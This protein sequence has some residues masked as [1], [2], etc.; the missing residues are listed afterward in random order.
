[1]QAL[2]ESKGKPDFET[3]LQ[4]FSAEIMSNLKTRNDICSS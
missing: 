3:S 4:K 2:R 1:M